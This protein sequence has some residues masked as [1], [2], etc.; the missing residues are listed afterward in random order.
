M[1]FCERQD[2]FGW[3]CLSKNASNHLDTKHKVFKKDDNK[4]FRLVKNLTNG[5]ALFSQ[6]LQLRNQ[7]VIPAKNF[8]TVENV[9]PALIPTMSKNMDEQHQVALTKWLTKRTEQTKRSVEICCTILTSQRVLLLRT[10]Y[11]QEKRRKRTFINLSLW[12]INWHNLSICSMQWTFYMI[13]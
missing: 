7:L 1:D 10:D 11:F 12:I 4:D 8:V 3:F 2:R 13:K 9:F 6:F 5:E